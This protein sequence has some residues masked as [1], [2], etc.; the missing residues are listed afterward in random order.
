MLQHINNSA[1]L[2]RKLALNNQILN[3]Q[4]VIKMRKIAVKLFGLLFFAS[5]LVTAGPSWAAFDPGEGDLVRGDEHVAVPCGAVR[6]AD[7][8]GA[9]P[10]PDA[11]PCDPSQP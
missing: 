9:E 10:R 5:Y 4:G 7:L 6:G 8:E 2:K 1:Y 3:R 11:R